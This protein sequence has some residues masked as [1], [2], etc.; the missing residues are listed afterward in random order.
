MLNSFVVFLDMC[1]GM[2]SIGNFLI[3]RCGLVKAI[4]SLFIILGAQ[5]V[6]GEKC[7]QK[8]P[9]GTCPA[10]KTCLLNGNKY[11]CY[12]SCAQSNFGRCLAGQS[13]LLNEGK[14]GCYDRCR[15]GS[16]GTCSKDEICMVSYFRIAK[17][18]KKIPVYGCF[19][20]TNNNPFGSCPAGKSCF[21]C[22]GK[23][24]CVEDNF[25]CEGVHKVKKS[26][27]KS[28]TATSKIVAG[29]KT[30][31]STAVPATSAAK[32]QRDVPLPPTSSVNVK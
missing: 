5:S 28:P 15:K 27:A 7:S 31:P 3:K 2:N 4:F 32:T 21:T 11:G 24:S 20:C 8:A 9:S 18:L 29:Q 23:T 12:G 1:T 14:Y 25:V 30:S 17:N 16:F 10:G 19:S 26:A 22:N 6:F 13:C